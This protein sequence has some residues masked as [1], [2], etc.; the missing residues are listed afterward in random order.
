MK[1]IKIPSTKASPENII[2]ILKI[3]DEYTGD[4]GTMKGEIHKYLLKKSKRGKRN[5][6]NSVYAISFPTLRRLELIQNK[7]ADVCLSADGNTLLKIYNEEGELE[8]K[9]MFAKVLMRIDNEKAHVIKNLLTLNKQITSFGELVNHL[10]KDDIDTSLEDDR[11]SRWL[12]FLRYVDFI[13]V[14]DGKI[15][16]NKFQ[17]KSIREGKKP[18]GF[19]TFVNTVIDEYNKIKIKKRGSIYVKIPELESEVC[20]KLKNFT[21]FDFREYIKRLKNFRVKGKKIM[22][23]KPG[24]REKG[25]I[26]INGTY[27]YYIT[28]YDQSE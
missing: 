19:D 1:F 6:Y 18:V 2:G 25:G 9:K 15:K 5:E 14:V 3:I 8:Y 13:D 11:L 7:G 20:G 22:F 24:A 26:K 21:T 27:Y 10:R 16:I 17:I 28:I 4:I 12:R 23:S